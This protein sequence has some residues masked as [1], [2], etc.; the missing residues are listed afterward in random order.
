[1]LNN[2]EYFE[3][4]QR[5]LD[6]IKFLWE[7]LNEYHR[8]RSLHHAGH[9]SR[10]TFEIRKRVLVEKTKRGA[11]RIDTA[12]DIMNDKLIG[13]CITS[14]TEHKRGELESIFIEI[15]YRKPGRFGRVL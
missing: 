9:F 15:E 2:I 4:D 5:G 3:T 14:V 13:Y 1:M 7:K 11:L 6:E 10:M 8:V 12:K